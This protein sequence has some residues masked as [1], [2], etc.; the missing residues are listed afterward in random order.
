[1][2]L[3]LLISNDL[4]LLLFV[5]LIADHFRTFVVCGRNID[6]NFLGDLHKFALRML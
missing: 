3:P 2:L 5:L 6:G 4:D 1:M